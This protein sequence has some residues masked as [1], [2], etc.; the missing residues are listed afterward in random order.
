MK[1]LTLGL[2]TLAAGTVLFG[3]TCSASAGLVPT[4]LAETTNGT[5]STF[6]YS[7]NFTSNGSTESLTSGDFFTL[8]DLGSIAG[9]TGSFTIS[10][11]FVGATAPLTAPVDSASILNVTGTYGGATVTADTSYSFTVTLP[12]TLG[13]TL[14]YYSSTDTISSGKNGQ[15]GR[16][17]VPFAA[18]PEPTT[19]AALALGA[20]GLAASAVRRRRSA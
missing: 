13:T 5:S 12:G 14:G 15:A 4:F 1:K 9:S 17:T 16:I 2:Q 8:Y 10:Q 19:C 11:A 6:V 7:I 20:F 3:L 18:V